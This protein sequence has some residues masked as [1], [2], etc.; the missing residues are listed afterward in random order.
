[1][2]LE[3]PLAK[4]ALRAEEEKKNHNGKSDRVFPL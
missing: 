1:M 2:C 3:D 4:H